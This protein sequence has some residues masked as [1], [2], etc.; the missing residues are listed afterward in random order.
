[1]KHNYFNN[2]KTFSK[3]VFIDGIPRVGKTALSSIIS[4]LNK[5]EL[6]QFCLF[7]EQVLPA[8]KYKKISKDFAKAFINTHLNEIIYN[9]MISRNIN[10]RKGEFTSAYS[11]RDKKIYLKRMLMPDGDIVI[12]RL[13]KNKNFF[14]FL[15]HDFMALYP[16]LKEMKL[17]YKLIEI[18]RNPFDIICSWHNKGFGSRFISDVRTWTIKAGKNNRLVPWYAFEYQQKYLNSTP[19]NR[20]IMN[21]INLLDLSV[22]NH[23][24]FQNDKNVITFKH[25]EFIENTNFFIKKISNFLESPVNGKSVTKLLKSTNL[26]KPYS[27]ANTEKNKYFIKNNTSK[28]QYQT[29]ENLEKNYLKYFYGI[30]KNVIS[31]K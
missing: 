13:K 31:V 18:Y 21:V 2:H 27:Y 16:Q 3:V 23:L 8:L 19:L 1:M 6:L 9:T 5:S 10:L 17:N 11:F 30:K 4:T 14:P 12:N 29:I 22:K 26:P 25:E 7:I 24:R 28:K 20:C 15:S